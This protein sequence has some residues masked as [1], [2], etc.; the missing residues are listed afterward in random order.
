MGREE[1][2]IEE[3][4]WREFST[5][6]KLPTLP[7]SFFSKAFDDEC[8]V[9]L[10]GNFNHLTRFLIGEYYAQKGVF[11]AQLEQCHA[12]AAV[13][14]KRMIFSKK[15]NYAKR[16][17]MN[18]SFNLQAQNSPNKLVSKVV[19]VELMRQKAWNFLRHCKEYYVKVEQVPSEADFFIEELYNIAI[20]SVWQEIYEDEV[21]GSGLLSW[22][23]NVLMKAEAKALGGKALVILRALNLK[24]V[25]QSCLVRQSKD[26]GEGQ[27]KEKFFPATIEKF[28][29][30]VF[31]IFKYELT[32]K[33]TPISVTKKQKE[34][35]AWVIQFI[36]DV[37]QIF[38]DEE[39][40]DYRI[41]KLLLWSERL[42]EARAYVLNVVRQKT[43][44]FWAWDLMAE[45]FPEMSKSCLA[46]ALCCKA[47]ERYTK[48]IIKRAKLIGLPIDD[49]VALQ[50]IANPVEEL[51]FKDCLRVDAIYVKTFVQKRENNCSVRKYLFMDIS[52]KLYSP[53]NEAELSSRD[54]VKEIGVP[55][56]LYL[57]GNQKI[58]RVEVRSSGKRYEGLSMLDVICYECTE[59]GAYC[60]TDRKNEYVLRRKAVSDT[61]ILLGEAYKLYCFKRR[62]KD[63]LLRYEP[64]ALAGVGERE[65]YFKTV[66]GCLRIQKDKWVAFVE[67]VVVPSAVIKGVQNRGIL[68]NETIPVKVK[69]V[70][71]SAKSFI[72]KNG[73]ERWKKRFVAISCDP[74]HGD[75]LEYYLQT[76]HIKEKRCYLLGTHLT[77]P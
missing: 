11:D 69:A 8:K 33:M 37:Y 71:I 9:T 36:E 41:A 68:L 25:P 24:K 75:E 72:D 2:T 76:C 60:F 52:G 35:L 18:A 59:H 50:E 1:C 15:K 27:R 40:G 28:A 23:G 10:L 30:A 29:T 46:R 48:K 4:L 13:W 55:V 16:K 53:V 66:Q 63:L 67:D 65:A 6:G 12:D 73:V 31:K 74:L 47:D 19:E 45:V 3:S 56:S 64:I 39:W 38:P 77:T 26:V 22:Y 49:F 14:V 21:L 70:Q 5:T 17:M 34:W 62:G 7:S 32:E 57:S 44:E 61:K 43:S 54:C 20:T 58:L 42:E 51:L